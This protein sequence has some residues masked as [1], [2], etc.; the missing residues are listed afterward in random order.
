MW[1]YK[2]PYGTVFDYRPCRSGKNPEAILGDYKG[3]IQTDRY[4]GY[5]ALFKE[6]SGR[7]SAACM[8]HARRKFM[9]IVKISKNKGVAQHAVKCIKRLYDIERKAKDKGLGPNE[10]LKLR[11]TQAVPILDELKKYLIDKEP[12]IPPRG[13]LHTAVCYFLRHFDALKRYTESPLIHI[14]N[15]PA[16]RAIKPFAVGRKN[17]LFCGNEKGATASANLYSLIE[18][19][20]AYNLKIFDYLQYVFDQLVTVNGEQDLIKLLPVNAQQHLPKIKVK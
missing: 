1:V 18:S 17:W 14:D 6:G 11:Q 19:A 3:Y 16:E 5:N 4:A 13:G 12:T 2:N 20:K 9:D 10:R 15:N 7:I 8:A